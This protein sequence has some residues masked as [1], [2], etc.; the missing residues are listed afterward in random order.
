M[1]AIWK[2][3]SQNVVKQLE[4]LQLTD[5]VKK[6]KGCTNPSLVAAI[7]AN[8]RVGVLDHLRAIRVDNLLVFA[9]QH[10]TSQVDSLERLQD[11]VG[12]AAKSVCQS[13]HAEHPYAG[14][15]GKQTYKRS[16]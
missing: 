12:L 10:A 6:V 7:S 15:D 16:A 2:R 4:V 3:D 13:L 8:N 1:E 9:K 11:L 14:W 5:L